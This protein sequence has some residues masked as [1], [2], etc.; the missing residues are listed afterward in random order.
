[1]NLLTTAAWLGALY[2]PLR[3][4]VVAARIRKR[5]W[6]L[7]P[8]SDGGPDEDLGLISV[9]VPARDEREAIGANVQSILGLEVPGGRERL[10]LV[11]VDDRSSDGTADVA[12]AAAEG[13]DR[14]RIVLGDGPP[15]GWMGKH[16]AVWRAVH[17]S[18]GQW[19]L[20]VDADVRLHPRA[21]RILL[22]AARTQ[23]ADM[24]SW[25]GTLVSVGPGERVL[26]P[27]IGDLISLSAP[28]ARVNDPQ[29]DDCLANGQCILIRREVYFDVG[30]HESIRASVVDD[31]SLA[32]SVKFHQPVPYRYLLFH[33][34]GLMW[35]RMYRSFAEVWRGFSKNFYAAAQGRVAL[36]GLVVG[37]ILATS[38]LP[39]ILL[40]WWLWTR[41]MRHVLPAFAVL[42]TVIYRLMTRRL[43]PV[44]WPYVFAHPFAALA[45][46]GIIADSVL[47]GVGWRKRVAWKGRSGPA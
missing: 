26:M 31:V 19:L 5:A 39:W 24:V 43:L 7:G 41:D 28:P 4:L 44:P 30:G 8:E 23:G 17:E 13:D 14:L 3:C 20:F 32:R 47:Q 1:M 22:H 46:V 21:L 12:R 16:A 38:V 45:T 40:P 18:R 42:F 10:E 34:D 9:C 15:P 33:A 25:L 37:Y 36:L 35:V 2:W 11:L 27:F 6:T 29:R